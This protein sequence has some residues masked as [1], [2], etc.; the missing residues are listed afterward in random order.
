MPACSED[1]VLY[2]FCFAR[3]GLEMTSTPPG[4]DDRAPVFI[5]PSRSVAAVVCELRRDEFCSPDARLDELAWI[6]PRACRHEG[7]VEAVMKHSPVL[8]ARFG[9]LFSSPDSLH[10]FMN[11]HAANITEFLDR[12]TG[13][14]EWAL[15]GSLDKRRAERVVL[16]EELSVRSSHLSTLSPGK[17]YLERQRIQREVNRKLHHSLQQ[18]CDQLSRK[19]GRYASAFAPRKLLLSA[20]EEN[21]PIVIFNWAFLLPNNAIS[22]FC[23]RVKLAGAEQLELGLTL[24][25]SGPWP[26]YSFVPT[27]PQ[28]P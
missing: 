12:V 28:E 24:H 17:L 4:V 25:L 19:L 7:V 11:Q 10:R 6:G 26:P 14:Q 15:K 13:Q 3:P 20:P 8:P 1:K 21:E 9:T 2:L 22:N 18:H 27:L 16:Q 5:H 23:A